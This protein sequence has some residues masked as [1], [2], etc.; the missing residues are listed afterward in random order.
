MHNRVNVRTQ[1][2]DIW[3]FIREP[4]G[5]T[6]WDPLDQKT[7]TPIM[8]A[9]PYVGSCGGCPNPP[10]LSAVVARPSS[11]SG[12]L[13]YLAKDNT[14]TG[15][16]FV[17]VWTQMPFPF[18]NSNSPFS[19]ADISGGI[20]SVYVVNPRGRLNEYV[21][22][23]N[24]WVNL[25][26]PGITYT[27]GAFA[28][29]AG[30][31]RGYTGDGDWAVGEFKGECY[32][33]QWITGVSTG[34]LSAP[35]HSIECTSTDNSA[36]FVS[37]QATLDITQ[38]DSGVVGSHG[39]A[40]WDPGFNRGE[41]A[42]GQVVTG[43]AESGGSLNHVRCSNAAGAFGNNCRVLSLANVTTRESPSNNGGDWAPGFFKGECR[44]GSAVAGISRD[45]GSGATHAVLCCDYLSM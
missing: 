42:S 5:G 29:D 39:L 32:A 4:G 33:N 27:Y 26:Y 22:S 25:G 37:F 36:A 19:R 15:A 13:V 41:C 7:A 11:S 30:D 3:A 14:N 40:N 6:G 12:S 43:L 10:E 34:G 38:G 16:S 35:T 31:S 17:D 45:P 18:A 20:G 8:S 44:N 2:N 1:A 24:Q 21:P 23:T 9:G 28:F